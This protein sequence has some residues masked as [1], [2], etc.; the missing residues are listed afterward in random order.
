MASQAKGPTGNVLNDFIGGVQKAVDINLKIQIPNF[1]MAF[2]C[3][4]ILEITGVLTILGKGLTPVM[5]IFALPGVAAVPV[6]SGWLSTSAA[7]GATVAMAEAGT[8][9][10]THCAIILPMTMALGG[11]QLFGRILT[12]TGTPSKY[13]PMITLIGFINAVFVGI[14]MRFLV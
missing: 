10:G 11:I 4:R 13:Y 6:L 3:I 5:G 12:V 9:T 2:V 1:I 7:I 14:I 8:L